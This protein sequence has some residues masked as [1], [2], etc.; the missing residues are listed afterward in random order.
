M[1]RR[2]HG[3]EVLARSSCARH[4][5]VIRLIVS[6]AMFRLRISLERHRRRGKKEA[7]LRVLL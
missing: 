3:G 5:R 1:S 6:I 4:A 7:L 2:M